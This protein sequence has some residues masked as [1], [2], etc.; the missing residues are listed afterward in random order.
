MDLA[1]DRTQGGP[2]DARTLFFGDNDGPVNSVVNSAR[3]DGPECV[4]KVN[5]DEPPY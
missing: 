1:P 2:G 3:H 4:A 5:V